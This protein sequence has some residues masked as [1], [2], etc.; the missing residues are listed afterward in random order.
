MAADPGEAAR[1]AD[2]ILLSVEVMEHASG[3]RLQAAKES[4]QILR[5]AQDD[6]AGA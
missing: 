4:A 6:K 3:F 1:P 2:G 5:L